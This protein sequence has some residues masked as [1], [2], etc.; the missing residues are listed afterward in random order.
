MKWLIKQF[1]LKIFFPFMII[2]FLLFT[3]SDWKIMRHDFLKEPAILVEG[4]IDSYERI[5]TKA[6]C[7]MMIIV[8]KTR[9]YLNMFS[10]RNEDSLKG[11]RVRMLTFPGTGEIIQLE[12]NSHLYYDMRQWKKKRHAYFGG[13]LFMFLLLTASWFVML[14]PESWRELKKEG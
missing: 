12:F 1:S 6:S 9:Y 14:R 7:H 5:N 11:S 4:P 8:N 3:L 10:C 13:D 2:L